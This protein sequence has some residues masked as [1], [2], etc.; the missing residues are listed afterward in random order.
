MSKLDTLL[1]IDPRENPFRETVAWCEPF[2]IEPP[3][4]TEA[5]LLL[6]GFSG[7]P[8]ECR[9]LAETLAALG[10]AVAAPRY[11]G[12][13]TS[14]ADFQA[15]SADDWLRRAYDAYLDLRGR[16]GTVHVAGH[17]MGGLIASAVAVSFGAPRAILLA[18]AFELADRKIRWSPYLAPFRKVI[19]RRRPQSEFDRADP[20]RRWLHDE[21]WADDLVSVS[22]ELYRMNRKCRKN[23][24]RLEAKTL[25]IAGELDQTVPA[26][27]AEWLRSHTPKAASFDARVIPG[28]GHLFPFDDR[29]GEMSAIVREWLATNR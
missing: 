20:A 17:S 14:R 22:A 2:E 6:H 18:P 26:S 29:S 10:Y 16:Y 25:V 19:V 15:T 9:P 1:G 28:A 27:V 13:G 4:A 24:A 11:P 8:G 7:Q 3:G 5:F 23:V 12:H 21:Y